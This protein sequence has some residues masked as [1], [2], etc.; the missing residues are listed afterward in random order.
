MDELP[1]E[2]EG[3]KTLKDFF[4]ACKEFIVSDGGPPRWF[5][6]LECVCRAPDSPLFLFLPATSFGKSQLK[7]LLPLL[8]SIP[9]EFFLLARNS[10]LTLT[11]GDHLRMLMDNVVKGIP[12]GQS[13]VGKL[14]QDIVAA[15]SN[16]SVLVEILPKELLE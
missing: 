2:E 16:P 3:R 5:S 11:T 10:M 1:E 9:D 14:S 15:L 13:V 7:P 8:Q 4:E 12:L 6:P